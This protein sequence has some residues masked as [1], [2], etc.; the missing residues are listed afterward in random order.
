MIE[1]VGKNI[2][3]KPIYKKKSLILT[4]EDDKP[5]HWEVLSI[6]FHVEDVLPGDKVFID[7]YGLI[8]LDKEN[9]IFCAP[10]EN[11]KAKIIAV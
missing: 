11:V 7:S 9:K 10:G 5:T 1:A 3:V 2:T 8:E 4:K 6:G